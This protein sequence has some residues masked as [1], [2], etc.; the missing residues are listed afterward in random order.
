MRASAL[1]GGSI[2]REPDAVGELVHDPPLPQPL[3]GRAR[4]HLR[5][6]EQRRTATSQ[7]QRRRQAAAFLAHLGRPAAGELRHAQL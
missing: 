4:R 3:S 5:A 6:G 7:Q 2:S 1:E